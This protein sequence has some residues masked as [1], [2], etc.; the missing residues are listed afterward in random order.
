M[1]QS[2]NDY[3]FFFFVLFSVR[4]HYVCAMAPFS[5]IEINKKRKKKT[6][7]EKKNVKRRHEW[8]KIIHIFIH[9]ILY[10]C[11]GTE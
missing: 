3:T 4:N 1:R 8:K 10:S 7:E 9:S 2:D 6:T 11:W 5:A